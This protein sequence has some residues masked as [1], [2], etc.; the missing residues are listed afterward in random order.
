MNRH[1][2]FAMTLNVAAIA[3][4]AANAAPSVGY[5]AQAAVVAASV[6]QTATFAIENMSCALCPVTVRKAMQNVP[7]VTSVKIDFEAKT[8]TAVFDPAVASSDAIGA[9]STN[10]GYPAKV[11]TANTI[12]TQ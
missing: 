1:W 3:G 11:T 12:Q 8:A 5:A 10:A 2:V 4:I 6:Q 9:A 7:G